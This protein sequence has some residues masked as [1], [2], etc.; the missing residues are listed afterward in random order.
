MIPP[1]TAWGWRVAVFAVTVLFF[2]SLAYVI[3]FFAGAI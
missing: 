3:A 2:A 1:Q